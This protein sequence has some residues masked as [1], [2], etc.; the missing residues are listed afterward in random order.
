MSLLQEIEQHGLADCEFNRNLL[1]DE[2]SIDWH[3][4]D[5]QEIDESLTNDEARQVLQLIKQNH[6]R[7]TGIN[8]ETIEAWID[9]F[10]A[11]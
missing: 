11:I 4:T 6:D 9:Y 1:P 3:F 7:T 2:I 8:W 5:V 10:K